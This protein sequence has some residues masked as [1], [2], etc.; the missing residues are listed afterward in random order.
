MERLRRALRWLRH[1]I[2]MASESYPYMIQNFIYNGFYGKS[3]SGIAPYRAKFK[4]WTNDPGVA[5]FECSDSKERLI[6]TFAIAARGLKKHPL[7]K[8]DMSNKVLFGAPAHS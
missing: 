6:P 2:P 4:E 7:P 3:L 5:V 1:L 8:Q